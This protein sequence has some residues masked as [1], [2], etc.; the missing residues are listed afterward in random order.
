MIQVLYLAIEYIWESHSAFFCC[1]LQNNRHW[2]PQYCLRQLSNLCTACTNLLCCKN[3]WNVFCWF[4][5]SFNPFL[6]LST[7]WF[8]TLSLSSFL[9]IFPLLSLSPPL[10][11]RMPKKSEHMFSF[12][13]HFP[14]SLCRTLWVPALPL[15]FLFPPFPFS[16]FPF[17]FSSFSFLDF[18]YFWGLRGPLRLPLIPV[19]VVQI[20]KQ[21]AF[22]F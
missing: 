14:L 9:L 11:L 13:F 10:L 19:V 8:L 21:G 22:F 12:S 15:L 2:R 1:F 3:F 18:L 16:S 17:P 5:F 6:P 7:S 20:K 4:F